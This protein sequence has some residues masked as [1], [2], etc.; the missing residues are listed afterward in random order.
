DPANVAY[1][2]YTSGSTGQPKGVL[3][4]HAALMN[5][6]EAQIRAFHVTDRSRVLQ[7]APLSFDASVSEILMAL[8]SGAELHLARRD[9]L[10]PGPDLTKLLQARRIT[11]LTLPPS[12]L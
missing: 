7:F 12:A 5:L 11:H 1:A 9:A 6:A 8:C 3:V 4:Q 2:I 10:M